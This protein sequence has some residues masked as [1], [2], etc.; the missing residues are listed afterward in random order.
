[1]PEFKRSLQRYAKYYL[2]FN[3]SI[4]MWRYHRP[5]VRPASPGSTTQTLNIF[6]NIWVSRTPKSSRASFIVPVVYYL[7]SSMASDQGWPTTVIEGVG[8]SSKISGWQFC[9]INWSHYFV[10]LSPWQTESSET[11][12][13]ILKLKKKPKASL[14]WSQ[15][16]KQT[17]TTK[18]KKENKQS[19]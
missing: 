3:S 4:G 5:T 13:N 6:S 19:I 8:F 10:T 2:R 18:N 16:L 15:N 7:R 14:Q 9:I 1:M 11:C 17:W 12:L